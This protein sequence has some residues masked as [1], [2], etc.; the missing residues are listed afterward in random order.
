MQNKQSLCW[1]C[2]R[3]CG[4]CSWSADFKPVKG[5]EAKPTII[6]SDGMDETESYHV[7]NCPLFKDDTHKYKC[8]SRIAP[9][10][11]PKHNNPT[12]KSPLRRAFEALPMDEIKRRL[13]TL[14]RDQD[15][16]EMAFVQG[17]TTAEISYTNG[18]C[19]DSIRKR[20]AEIVREVMA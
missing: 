3:F 17:M 16:A 8:D 2:A 4:N 7:I 18:R 9:P 5:W 11:K 1:S 6:R 20:I 14:T 12:N 13:S 10:D 19:A 15:I